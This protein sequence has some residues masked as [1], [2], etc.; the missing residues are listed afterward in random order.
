MHPDG[1]GLR[2][3][4]LK[5][6][7]RLDRRAFKK[8]ERKLLRQC[9][10]KSSDGKR[11]RTKAK[12]RAKKKAASEAADAGVVAR[13]HQAPVPAVLSPRY[14]H[15]RVALWTVNADGSGLLKLTHTR[16]LSQ[17]AWGTAPPGGL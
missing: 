12:Q 2:K 5:R 10:E 15:R 13:Q 14:R 3:I 9:K 8:L 1:T 6:L 7:D 16:R 11:C 4:A 17:Y